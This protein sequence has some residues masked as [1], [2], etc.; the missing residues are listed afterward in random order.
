M[1]NRCMD[2]LLITLEG[3]Q[4]DRLKKSIRRISKAKELCD[5][6]VGD[7]G[8]QL[9]LLRKITI[10]SSF[11]NHKMI[12]RIISWN[13]NGEGGKPAAC[14]IG[15]F[16]M[17]VNAHQKI[18][19]SISSMIHQLKGSYKS[20]C[21]ESSGNQIRFNIKFRS[22]LVMEM[23]KKSLPGDS[24]SSSKEAAVSRSSKA[25][26][27]QQCLQWDK[28]DKATAFSSNKVLSS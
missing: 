7:A 17:D 8:H 20:Q 19:K 16:Q 6:G 28:V 9:V 4:K 27:R 11:N 3:D 1:W 12:R 22:S 14:A 15:S 26:S 18:V 25:A 21:L 10:G 2:H 5:G 13:L 23:Q 24:V